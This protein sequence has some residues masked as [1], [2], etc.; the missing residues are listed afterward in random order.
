MVTIFKKWKR[1]L[2]DIF[3]LTRFNEYVIFVIV[4]TLM[5][6]MIQESPI[7]WRLLLVLVANWL[8]V[9][10]AFMY[11]DIEDAKDDACDP[12]KAN[13]NPV[14]A[15]RIS[16]LWAYSLTFCV[17]L[18][19]GL[20]YFF[21]GLIPFF[22]G[23]ACLVLGILYSWKRIRLKRFPVLDLIS[24]VLMLA[25]LQLLCAYTIFS[26]IT[27]TRWIAPFIV[28]IAV[29]MYGELFN[30][31]RDLEGDRKAGLKHTAALV[32]ERTAHIM[33]IV[34]L[35]IAGL[36]LVYTILIGIIPWWLLGVL[37]ILCIILLVRPLIKAKRGSMLESSKP[38]QTPVLLIGAVGLAIWLASRLL[39]F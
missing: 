13:R 17:A 29:S 28:V 9:G 11:N 15:G 37:A 20:I 8:A 33:M 36:A 3:A 4:T 39:G 25:G 19:A 30:E 22:L 1:P 18:A 27:A 31:V 10:F 2:S 38:F 32:G 6:A 26:P 24:H 16:R 23:M 5:G 7:D 12:A 35:V 14:S 21:L 34:V